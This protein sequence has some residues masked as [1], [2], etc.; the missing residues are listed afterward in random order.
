MRLNCHQKQD[1]SNSSKNEGIPKFCLRSKTVHLSMFFI[2]LLV[3]LFFSQNSS[4]WFAIETR[5]VNRNE[6]VIY[7]RWA[8]VTL[9]QAN[10]NWGIK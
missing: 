2:S 9:K 4:V 1:A 10:H 7:Y 3:D 8:S 6:F 5:L